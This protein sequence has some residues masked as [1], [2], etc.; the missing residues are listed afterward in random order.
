M[1]VVELCLER[2]FTR[3]EH[4]ADQ[5]RPIA[6][7][8]TDRERVPLAGP[9]AEYAHEELLAKVKV[10]HCTVERARVSVLGLCM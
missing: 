2:D 9:A 7:A 8:A 3:A 10:V 1:D 6:P 4:G 5:T